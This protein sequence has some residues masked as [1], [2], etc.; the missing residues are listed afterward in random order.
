MSER[1][2][3][4]FK[5]AGQAFGVCVS[6]IHD[7]FRPTRIT[8]VPLASA[9]IAGVLN[10]RGR[11]VTAIEVRSRLGL[12]SREGGNEASLAIGVERNGES[13]G[14]VIDEIGEVIRLDDEACEANPA[15]LD[16]VWASISRGVHRLDDQLLVVMD[17]DR[18]LAAVA[19]DQSIA[20]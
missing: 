16:P 18:M 5:V 17:I 9:E 2:Y 10:L 4:T 8:P 7:V 11:I 14:L 12:Q 3:V 19:D 13:F 20:A 6:E 15:N 1:E